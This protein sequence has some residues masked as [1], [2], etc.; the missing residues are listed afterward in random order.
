MKTSA[1]IVTICAGGIGFAATRLLISGSNAEHHPHAEPNDPPVLA[2]RRDITSSSPSFVWSDKTTAGQLLLAIAW[3]DVHDPDEIRKRLDQLRLLP[4]TSAQEAARSALLLNWLQTDPEAACQW[5]KTDAPKAFRDTFSE[6]ARLDRDA[7]L[8]YAKTLHQSNSDL[9][10][11]AFATVANS[12]VDENPKKAFAFLEELPPNL[13]SSYFNRVLSKLAETDPDALL[14][15]ADNQSQDLQKDCR[16]A[17]AKALG[18]KDPVRALAWWVEQ[19][20]RKD[21][22]SRVFG[23]LPSHQWADAIALY[24]ATMPGNEMRLS[25]VDAYSWARS[26]PAALLEI[27][28]SVPEIS[29]ND[30]MRYSE[31]SITALAKT[32]PA[33]ALDWFS[34]QTDRDSGV[35]EKIAQIWDESDSPDARAAL[36]QLGSEGTAALESVSD[37][38]TQSTPTPNTATEF[39]KRFADNEGSYNYDWVD[40]LSFE[41]IEKLPAYIEELSA[42][43]DT[44]RL[45]DL[46]SNL[47]GFAPSTAARILT[48]DEVWPFSESDDP[49]SKPDDRALAT[50]QITSYWADSDPSSAAAWVSALPQGEVRDAAIPNLVR[51]WEIYDPAAASQWANALPDE[52]S[53]NAAIA[54]LEE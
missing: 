2:A 32:D 53:R 40:N 42:Q 29:E 5:C 33:A 25:H 30:K 12:I 39:I 38:V 9:A 13:Y 7:A 47:A 11:R 54:A 41:E 3:G 15:F 34:K 36:L 45:K 26:D 21:L 52:A 20:D 17:F 31:R 35:L 37:G 51:R 50:A 27:L 19:T 48:I 10:T 18:K 16:R 4:A 24:Q 22:S 8:G 43:S 49:F 6:W 28:E 44:A 23:S 46:V 1:F 14:A